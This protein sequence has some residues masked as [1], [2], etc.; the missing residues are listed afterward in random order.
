MDFK[1]KYLSHE[2][3]VRLY[4]SCPNLK[5]KLESNAVHGYVN[6]KLCKKIQSKTNIPLKEVRKYVAELGYKLLRYRQYQILS[7]RVRGFTVSETAQIL[8]MDMS[9]CVKLS[10]AVDPLLIEINET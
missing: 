10:K 3:L 4:E 5:Q 1:S 6:A 2:R 8:K 9:N 7:L